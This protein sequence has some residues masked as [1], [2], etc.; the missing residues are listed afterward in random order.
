MKSQINKFLILPG[1]LLAPVL[2]MAVDP[3]DYTDYLDG[4]WYQCESW[5]V[6]AAGDTVYRRDLS[7]NRQHYKYDDQHNQVYWMNHHQEECFYTFTD[8]GKQLSTKC[9]NGT[10]SEF[11]YDNLGRMIRIEGKKSD[12]FLEYDGE[13]DRV[14]HGRIVDKSGQI[15]DESWY[16]ND[17]KK[18]ERKLINK[19][20]EVTTFRPLDGPV[21]YLNENGHFELWHD[22]K[23]NVIKRRNKNGITEFKNKYDSKG[24]IIYNGFYD[25]W[26]RYF[27]KKDTSYKCWVD[28][29]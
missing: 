20:G 24:R 19:D 13:T 12:V 23:G 3:H 28:G 6:D 9:S 16:E 26:F 25:Q 5:V 29:K 22:D 15:T 18:N 17:V 27:T 14:I 7:G 11:F 2:L 4:K 10:L 1:I 21:K 8:T